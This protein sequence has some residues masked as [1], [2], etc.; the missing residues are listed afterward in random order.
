MN[1]R[2]GLYGE[3]SRDFLTYQGLVLVHHDENQ[4][5]FLVPDTPVRELPPDIPAGQ[6]LPIRFHPDLGSVEW[7]PDGDIAGKEQFRDAS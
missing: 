4:L 2:Y 1:K 5:R 7:T 6:T 3:H